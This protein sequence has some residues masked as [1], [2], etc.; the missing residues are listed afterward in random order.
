MA[1][2]S[3]VERSPPSPIEIW[4]LRHLQTFLASLGRLSAAPFATLLTSSVIGIALALPMGMFVL[5]SGVN[6]LAEGWE[7][8]AGITMFMK[9]EVS[10]RRV[11][12]LGAALR[13]RPDVV[14]VELILPDQAL[15]EFRTHS[16]LHDA[17]DMLEENP[18]PAVIVIEPHI[19]PGDAATV[20]ALVAE[21]RLLPEVDSA[22]L[23]LIWLQ[24]F[25]ALT[26]IVQRSIGVLITLF[27]LA[28]LLITGNTIRLEI[29]NRSA[30]I[31]VIKT[32]GG[33][34]AFIRRPFLYN[35]L[36]Y[37]LIG[38]VIAWLLVAFTLHSMSGAIANL[39]EL[40]DSDMAMPRMSGM[41]VIALIGGSTLLGLAGS[42]M[43]VDRYIR[44]IEPS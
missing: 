26:E 22:Q 30:E 34:D 8:S 19:E 2:R 18:L 12:E 5:L 39:A 14:N 13:T 20:E 4:L 23:D 6:Q 16:G 40:Y 24:R 33:T 28:V 15:A 9:K 11:A 31:E 17:L 35:G 21:L 36:I 3:R 1:N 43:V 32:V 42:W 44:A 25:R 7:I 27:A 41:Q 29:G 37:G 10:D 38:G